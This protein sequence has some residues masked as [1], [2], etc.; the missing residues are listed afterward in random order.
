MRETGRWSGL[1]SPSIQIDVG[2]VRNQGVLLVR[3]FMLSLFRC[4]NVLLSKV[5]SIPSAEL[6]KMAPTK[7]I[8][9][10]RG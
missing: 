8:A 5:L 4:S 3:V 7:M 10:G 9:S 6:V 2:T 1:Q